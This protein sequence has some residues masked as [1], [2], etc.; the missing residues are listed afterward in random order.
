MA[1]S[2]LKN[3]LP[4]STNTIFKSEVVH[5]LNGEQITLNWKTEEGYRLAKEAED[6]MIA[7]AKKLWP[8]K[9]ANR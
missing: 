9:Y 3:N 5:S 2:E 7:S 6:K 1:L 4:S 8:E